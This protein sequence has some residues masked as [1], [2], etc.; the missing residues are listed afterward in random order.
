MSDD[1]APD[2]TQDPRE[3]DTSQV[4]YPE[5]N[6]EPASPEGGQ[7]R[8]G[9]DAGSDAPSPSTDK[10]ADRDHSTGNPDAAG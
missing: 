7:D 6:P 10:E 4:G 1:T 5:S 8:S 3:S 2:H 9:G